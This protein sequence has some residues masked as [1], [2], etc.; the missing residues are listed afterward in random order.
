MTGADDDPE[1]G[2][3]SINEKKR[4]FLL[5][6]NDDVGPDGPDEESASSSFDPSTHKAHLFHALEGLERY[7]NYLQRWSMDDVD[8]LELALKEKLQQVRTQKQRVIERR[9]YMA[10][11]V[12]RL[13]EKDEKFR[14]LIGVPTSWTYLQEQVLDERAVKAIFRSRTFR[15]TA[16][17]ASSSEESS[18]PSVQDV[19]S[20]KVTVELDPEYLEDLMDQ[21][22]FDVYSFPLLRKEFCDRIQAFVRAVM[23]LLEQDND[24]GSIYR[25]TTKDLDQLGL[26]WIN[27]LLFH[28]ILRPITKHLYYETEAKGDLDWRQGYIAAYSANPSTTR[29]R[30]RLVPHTDDSEVTLNVNIGDVF[31][32]GKLEMR[33]L[34]DARDAG[35]LYGIYE[36]QLGRALIHAGRHLHEVTPITKG[37][38]FAYIMWAR[39]WSGCRSIT[40]PCCWLNRRDGKSCSCGERWN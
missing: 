26:T 36:P 9:E 25:G 7:P 3:G 33:G 29:P 35:S 40:C 12:S 32:G 10:T 4:R 8:L 24:S 17:R 5:A 30:E 22:M 20:G 15:K 13:L 37:E 2:G 14:D 21:E 27:D 34:R 1:I 23:D 38:R 16:K 31:E 6:D 11:V 19:L 18:P 28:L 39:S